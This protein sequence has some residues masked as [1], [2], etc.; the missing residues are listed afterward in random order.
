MKHVAEEKL[1]VYLDC[2]AVQ[3]FEA[4]TRPH[5]MPLCL[6]ILRGLSKALAVPNPPQSCWSSLCSTTEKIYNHLP[7]N[8]Q[9]YPYIS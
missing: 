3:Q 2:L 8:I 6:S 4:D 1:Q 7:D 9:V 5:R